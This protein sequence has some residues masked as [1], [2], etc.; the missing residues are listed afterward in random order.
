MMFPE[1]NYNFCP[2]FDSEEQSKAA[3]HLVDLWGPGSHEDFGEFAA[4]RS[5]ITRHFTNRYGMAALA[6]ASP[7]WKAL[8]SILTTCLDIRP[9]RRPDFATFFDM[10]RR[11]RPRGV[12]DPEY[13][14]KIYLNANWT[15]QFAVGERVDQTRFTGAMRALE[16]ADA[17]DAAALAKENGDA[18]GGKRGGQ[19]GGGDPRPPR[20]GLLFGGA[21]GM[22]LGGGRGAQQG[23][24][25]QQG[26]GGNREQPKNIL[27]V[28][29]RAAE[30][31]AAALEGA[32]EGEPREQGF[33]GDVQRPKLKL[34][35]W[36][37]AAKRRAASV[38]EENEEDEEEEEEAEEETEGET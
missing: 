3:K 19:A 17:E 21:N 1:T 28:G 26:L 8:Q 2:F 12:Q 37:G 13:F 36:G 10:L 24:P 30:R 27:D 29:K 14:K 18:E 6:T 4:C 38:D 33:A 22:R 7:E 32:L 35:L 31:R 15:T 20:K 11:D 16:K 25:N 5:R 23:Q 9:S 34:K